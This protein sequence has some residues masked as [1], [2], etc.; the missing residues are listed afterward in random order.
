M[1]EKEMAKNGLDSGEP[2]EITMTLP[3]NAYFLSGIR[4]FTF[5][6]TKNLTQFS[7]QWAHRFQSVVDELCNNANEH[8]SANGEFITVKF[9]AKTNEWL[10]VHVSDSGTGPDKFKANELKDLVST[11]QQEMTS[12]KFLGIRGRG[13]PQIVANWTDELVFE[14]NENG[15][16]TVKIKKYLKEGDKLSNNESAN[17]KE[18]K[19]PEVTEAPKI[20]LQIQ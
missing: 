19:K 8:G 14:D 15:G 16:V 20:N 18:A 2:V 3:T 1:E 4:D 5:N 12:G 7:E 9:I 10:E 11:R 17:T 13:L 6:L